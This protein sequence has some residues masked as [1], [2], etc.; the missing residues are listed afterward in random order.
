MATRTESGARDDSIDKQ[1]YFE[2]NS[3]RVQHL[4]RREDL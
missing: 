2:R 1:P 3:F 4:K